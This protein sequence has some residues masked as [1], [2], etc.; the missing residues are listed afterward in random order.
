MLKKRISDD[1]V[2]LHKRQEEIIAWATGVMVV[3][4][5]RVFF[6]VLVPSIELINGWSRLADNQW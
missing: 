3:V 1:S 6:V 2:P 4:M 5:I